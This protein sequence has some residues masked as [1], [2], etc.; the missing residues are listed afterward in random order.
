MY[1]VVCLCSRLDQE[2]VF[3]YNIYI[4]QWMINTN[5]S[6]SCEV[7]WDNRKKRRT[8]DKGVYVNDLLFM[9]HHCICN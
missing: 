1:G 4:F 2:Y 8:E 3:T 9:V 6:F 7:Q 5:D